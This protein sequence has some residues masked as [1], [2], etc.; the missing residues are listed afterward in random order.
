VRFSCLARLT[1]AIGALAGSCH[2]LDGDSDAITKEAPGT[3]GQLDAGVSEPIDFVPPEVELEEN[4]RSPIVSGPF[5]W[6]ANP[7]TNRVARIDS[8]TLQV[9]VV[10]AGHGP[11]YLA[12]LPAGATAGGALALNVLGGDAS[13]FTDDSAA[14][15]ASGNGIRVETVDVQ[16]GASAWAVGTSGTFAIAW[17]RFEE[18]LRGP[19]DGYQDLTVLLLDGSAPTGTKL[20]VGFR[21]SEVVINEQETRAYVVSTP[22]ISVIDLTSNPARVVRELGLPSQESGV[23]R[24]VSLTPDGALAFVRLYRSPDVLVVRTE[25]D[26]RVT[27]SLPREVTDVDLSRDGTLAV[28]VMRGTA[29]SSAGGEQPQSGAG[30]Q[31][32]QA[33]QAG[34]GGETEQ[35]GQAGAAGQG[36]QASSLT[37]TQDSQVALLP[38]PAIFDSPADYQLVATPE[39]VGSVVLSD[40]GSQA[41]LFTNAVANTRLSL[42][43]L[44]TRHMRVV[45]VTAP[46]QAAF[47]SADGQHAVTVMTPPPGSQRAGAFGLVSVRDDSPPRIQGTLT[48]PR[49]VSLSADRVLVTT[50]GSQATQAVTFLGRFPDL[51]VD[52][53]ELT[54]EPLASGVVAET[55]QGFVAQNHPEGRVTFF[56][57]ETAESRT[58]TGFE[59]ASEVV[60]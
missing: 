52:R 4:F 18:D 28:A 3:G 7:E 38:V 14:S 43:D 21:P 34:Q 29:S 26:Q 55:G 16:D 30:G 12:A 25:D 20:S 60:D 15:G 39:L 8:H 5:L 24:D 37:E 10:D 19:L 23:S 51:S 57:L 40:D 31:S 6:T 48:V 35:S 58:V 22:G 11:T 42:L 1:V 32:G 17:S 27:V 41:L 36:G 45:D 47:V 53:F 59:L 44:E 13:I 9:E 54:N 56:D 33:G 46:I 2:S 50:W 49:F